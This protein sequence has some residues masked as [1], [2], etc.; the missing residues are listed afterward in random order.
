VALV[1]IE[2]GREQVAEE[3]AAVLSLKHAYEVFRSAG[4]DNALRAA[5]VLPDR[6]GAGPHLVDDVTVSTSLGE[7]WPAAEIE[8][9]ELDRDP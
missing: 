6:I 5:I 7:H 2:G 9:V 8:G 1:G 4:V 3:E